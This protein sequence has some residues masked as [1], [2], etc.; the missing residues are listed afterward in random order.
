MAEEETIQ[1]T[2]RQGFLPIES[3]HGVETFLQLVKGMSKTGAVVTACP[4]KH[5]NLDS[6]NKY[7]EKISSASLSSINKGS[8]T[9]LTKQLES[10]DDGAKRI[11]IITTTIMNIADG[12]GVVGL[13]D[14]TPFREAGLDSLSMV[15]IIKKSLISDG[16]ELFN[17]KGGV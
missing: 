6:E 17:K 10:T 14:S 3:K 12:L 15:R 16:N 9:S 2:K 7:F 13:D 4:L 8:E 11:P 5:K 1:R